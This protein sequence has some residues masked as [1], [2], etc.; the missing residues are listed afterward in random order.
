MKPAL[1]KLSLA[2]FVFA[3]LAAVLLAEQQPQ[4]VLGKIDFK[5]LFDA[6]PL[7][8][9]DTVEAGK[10]TYGTDFNLSPS[11]ADVSSFYE[12]FNKRVAAARN[13][14]KGAVDARPANRDALAQR[15]IAQANN[16]ALISRM[17]G[18]EKMSQMSEVEAQQAAA[19]AVG[20]YQQ[21]QSGAPGNASAMQAMMQRLMS[22][23]AYQERFEKMSKKEQEAELQK[24]M[25]NT[26]APAPP[27]APTAA[28][29]RAAQATD[30]ATAVMAKQNEVAAIFQRILGIDV[31]FVQKD[32]AIATGA[33]SH[34][35]IAQ[36]TN[37]KIAKIPMVDGGEAGPMPD[38]VQYEAALR[39]RATLDRN[40]AALELQQRTVLYAERK[41]KYKEAA[42]SYAAWLKQY[43]GPVNNATAKL[44]ND[45][46]ADTA[47]HCEE[48]L[49]NLAENLRKYNEE[50]TRDAAQYEQVYQKKM[51]ER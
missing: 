39:E 5:V 49:I 9:V 42:A 23:P 45:A 18:V 51:S 22:D 38:P 16:S 17:G 47:L 21:S 4:A 37:A 3:A 36:Q 12:P 15:S 20:S 32:Q 11:T 14:I 24:Y 34:A 31:E 50:T 7:M 41:A 44:L 1:T 8:P 35:Q 19:Q 6:A 30:E 26:H 2:L 25:G 27:A 40:R 33:G 29:Q 48:E 46:T 10:R 28:D 13:V 43:G